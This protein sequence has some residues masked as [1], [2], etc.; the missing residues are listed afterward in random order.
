MKDLKPYQTAGKSRGKASLL[1]KGLLVS[2]LLST[3]SCRMIDEGLCR[4]TLTAGEPT[5]G[6]EQVALRPY[7]GSLVGNKFSYLGNN[8]P[9]LVS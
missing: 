3:E 8:V 2:T 7:D 4:H 9:S 6:T 5:T 1:P